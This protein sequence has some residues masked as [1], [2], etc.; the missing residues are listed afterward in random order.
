MIILGI[1]L[2]IK[3]GVR[4]ET[5]VFIKELEHSVNEIPSLEKL[6]HATET[7]WVTLETLL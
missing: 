4:L 6:F 3:N 2:R 7:S 1:L 5:R